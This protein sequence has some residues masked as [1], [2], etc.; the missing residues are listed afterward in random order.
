MEGM[1]QFTPRLKEAFSWAR[2]EAKRLGSRIIGTEHLL[3]GLLRLQQ[4]LAAEVLADMGLD[5]ARVREELSQQLMIQVSGEGLSRSYGVTTDDGPIE[6]T[7]RVRKV[8]MMAAAESRAMGQELTGTEHLLLALIREKDSVAGQILGQ[9]NIDFDSC[10]EEIVAA[11]DAEAESEGDFPEEDRSEEADGDG[12]EGL[13]RRRSKLAALKSFARDLTAIAAEG[14]LDPVIGRERETQRCIQILCRRTK[15]NPIL[16]GEAG[17]GKTAI[18]EG[19][20]QAIASGEIPDVLKDKRIYALDLPLMIAGTKFRGQF[21]ERLKAVMEE[22]RR[23]GN[24]ILFL[25]EVHTLVGAGSGEGS[26]DASNILKPALSR[27]EIQCIG[28]TTV[29]EY[30]KN[31]EKDAALERRFQMVMVDQPS[32]ED[33]IE[34]LRGIRSRYEDYHRITYSDAAIEQAVLLS[35]RYITDRQ[36]PDKAIDLLDEA[37]ASMHLKSIERPREIRDLAERVEEVQSAKQEAVR[38]QN[39]ERA[40]AL[41]DEEK[42]LQEDYETR[43]K[44]W[45]KSIQ[46]ERPVVDVDDILRVVSDWTKIPL[47]RMEEQESQRLLALVDELR[48]SVIGQDDAAEAIGRA[49]RRSR[50]DLKDPQRPI[51]SF[52]FLGPT[53][54]GKT[55]LAKKLAEFMFGKSDAIIQV[56]MSEYMEKFALSRM[57]GSP[58]GY[59]GH[60]DGGQLTEQVRRRPYSVV[61]FDEVEK[62]HPDVLQILL[63]VLEE[64]RMTDSLGRVVDFK[65]TILILTSNIGA[66]FFQKDSNLGFGV[67]SV[68]S[69]FENLRAKVLEETKQTFKPEF[70]NRLTDVIV[71]HPLERPEME[72]ILG[73]ELEKIGKKL[74]PREVAIAF[75]EPAKKFLMDRGFDVKYGARPLRRA[76]EKYVEDPLAEL[77]L[78]E[79]LRPGPLDVGCDGESLQFVHRQAD[80]AAPAD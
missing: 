27:G 26:M 25:D 57:I 24:I 43:L 53:G 66:E 23:N 69:S 61:L 16:L 37:G 34:I 63:Q 56:D 10:R 49:L 62:A 36:L 47:R 41:R 55:L 4:C 72:K 44:S 15:N 8:I 1:N 42:T 6:I 51:G 73:L 2:R 32:C 71:F 30:R 54:V 31:I 20:A 28:A 7:P 38:A 68:N 35:E 9:L 58:P 11:L 48:V 75:S 12:G 19:L 21:E 5:L 77:V 60:D 76:L 52:L 33:A 50:T 70:L 74:A 14:K 13:P 59:V 45:R 39:F 46:K 79:E 18:V 67:S 65:N 29:S 80:A 17:V 64:G 3:L 78:R 22:I 40:A